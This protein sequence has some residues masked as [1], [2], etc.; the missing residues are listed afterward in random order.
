MKK[1]TIVALLAL[2]FFFGG[3]R[4]AMAGLPVIDWVQLGKEFGLDTAA[5]VISSAL[6][7]SM[8]T[9]TAQWAN[10]GFR[11]DARVVERDAEGNPTGRFIFQEQPGDPTFIVNPG[12][13]FRNISKD[14][15]ESFLREIGPDGPG[16]ESVFA[17]FRQ[18][19]L[20]GIAE[21]TRAVSDD[22]FEKFRT[23]FE[24]RE[25]VA[26]REEFL[27]DFTRGGWATFLETVR[28]PND[29]SCAR[30]V[31][32]GE[33]RARM[34]EA[35]EQKREE[36]EQGGGFLTIRQC[37]RRNEQTGK[38]LQYTNV[39]P[40]QLIGQQVAQATRVEFERTAEADELQE[41]FLVILE[42][43][44]NNLIATGLS[45]LQN[46][47]NRHMAELGGAPAA[48]ERM[49][50]DAER[51]TRMR[52][53]QVEGCVVPTTDPDG[54]LCVDTD[55][56]QDGNQ[57]RVILTRDV[58]FAEI[59]ITRTDFATYTG[60]I[61]IDGFGDHRG[62]I[63]VTPNTLELTDEQATVPAPER[64]PPFRQQ[65]TTVLRIEIREEAL[66][67][68]ENLDE[69]SGHILIGDEDRIRLR[70]EVQGEERR[71]PGAEAGADT[72]AGADDGGGW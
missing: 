70:I 15:V 39:T 5:W 68:I 47:I 43:V 32:L 8:S 13:F 37:A 66:G 40:G 19:L 46:E 59:T 65:Q 23:T 53:R 57:E 36:L 14:S 33:A 18:Q 21:E 64:R 35:V 22:F 28:C 38:C 16:V 54:T 3:T 12:V 20:Q 58:P 31:V 2:V 34:Q 1:Y 63:T 61:V 24:R 48:Y 55:P 41:A 60:P 42:G 69:L 49:A 10:E 11:S 29:Y 6:L 17:D 9:Q 72:G 30:L 71:E 45:E 51:F 50:R 44:L 52:T 62:R 7:G 56:A 27:M 4:S 67:E 26:R 25:D